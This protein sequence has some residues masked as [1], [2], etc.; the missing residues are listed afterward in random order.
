MCLSDFVTAKPSM[1]KNDNC[2]GAFAL[3]SLFFIANS[4]P[5]VVDRRR[6]EFVSHQRPANRIYLF[7]N[8]NFSLSLTLTME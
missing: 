1:P 5:L 4:A 8:S 3:L 6:P 2:M 7:I